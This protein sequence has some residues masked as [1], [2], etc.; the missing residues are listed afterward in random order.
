MIHPDSWSIAWMKQ[1]AAEN[2]FSDYTYRE[3]NQSILFA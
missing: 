1:V 2:N 3:I